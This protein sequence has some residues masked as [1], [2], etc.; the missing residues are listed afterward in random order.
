MKIF[1]FIQNKCFLLN[2]NGNLTYEEYFGKSKNEFF[3]NQSFLASPRRIIKYYH[4]YL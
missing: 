1:D 3:N 2:E 4:Y